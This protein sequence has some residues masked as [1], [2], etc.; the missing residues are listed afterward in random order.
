MITQG[1]LL[2]PFLE[3]DKEHRAASYC[4]RSE[5]FNA[6]IKT[7]LTHKNLVYTSV[8]FTATFFKTSQ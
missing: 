6:V 4:E 8:V 1:H 2:A 5:L 3:A 7:K